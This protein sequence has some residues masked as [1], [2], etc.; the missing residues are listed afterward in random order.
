MKSI[1]IWL[2]AACLSLMACSSR[3]DNASVEAAQSATPITSDTLTEGEA[4]QNLYREAD[5]LMN[6]GAI[7]LDKMGEYV[8]RATVYT[9]AHPD[10]TLASKYLF[11]A[12]VFQM[13]IAGAQPDEGSRNEQFFQSIAI[14]DTLIAQYPNFPHL[15]YCYWYKGTIYENLKRV[16]DAEGEYRTLV[17]RYPQSA[18]AKGVEQYLQ[19]QGYAKDADAIMYDIKTKK[20]K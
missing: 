19:T 13:K 12:A 18:L 5:S 8:Q 1:Y 15:D 16:S 11:F 14:F 7:N 20:V 6:I 3:S 10:D 2:T 9:Q 17:H 4:L